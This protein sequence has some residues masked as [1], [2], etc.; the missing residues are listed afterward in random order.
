MKKA[1]ALNEKATKALQQPKISTENSQAAKKLQE[2]A[3]EIAD[4]VIELKRE[5]AQFKQQSDG[6]I[7]EIQ[8]L[9]KDRENLEA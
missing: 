1:K 3:N 9:D 7:P 5:R 6:L 4:D 8:A 2:D